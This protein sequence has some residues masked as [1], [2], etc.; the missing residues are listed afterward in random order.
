MINSLKEHAE[1]GADDDLQN[2]IFEFSRSSAAVIED[3]TPWGVLP[4][5]PGY[6][7][8]PPTSDFRGRG[9]SDDRQYELMFVNCRPSEAHFCKPDDSLAKRPLRPSRAKI[10][11]V[12]MTW[13]TFLSLAIGFA[14][15][16]LVSHVGAHF[17]TIGMI[18]NQSGSYRDSERV[19]K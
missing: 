4:C 16:D 14:I 7:S 13:R 3:S 9:F 12:A 19:R 1:P 11:E 17:S 6:L 2:R 8:A 10:L 18:E 15:F 5:G